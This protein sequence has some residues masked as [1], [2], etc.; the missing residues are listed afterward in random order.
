MFQGRADKTFDRFCGV[1]VK[2]AIKYDSYV[3]LLE[4]LSGQWCYCLK[5]GRPGRQKVEREK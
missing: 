4:Q 5:R 3:V 1:K 2:K